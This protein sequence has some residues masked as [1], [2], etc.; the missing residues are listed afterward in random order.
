MTTRETKL[1]TAQVAAL[2]LEVVKLRR[3][4]VECLHG[5]ENCSNQRAA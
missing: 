4:D 5:L 1:L 2:E 3:K